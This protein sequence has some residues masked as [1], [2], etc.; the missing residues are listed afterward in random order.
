M[1]GSCRTLIGQCRPMM[2]GLCGLFSK[3]PGERPN[4]WRSSAMSLTRPGTSR[5]R[6]FASRRIGKSNKQNPL[7]ARVRQLGRDAFLI[8]KTIHEDWG[9]QHCARQPSLC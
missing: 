2:R 6:S 7:E 8:S 5:A 3:A 1:A 9:R 4:V